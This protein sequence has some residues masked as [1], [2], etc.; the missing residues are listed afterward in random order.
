[1]NYLKIHISMIIPKNINRDLYNYKEEQL[2]KSYINPLIKLLMKS[3]LLYKLLN[4]YFHLKKNN[5]QLGE[6]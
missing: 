4:A 2:S 1:M 5:K 3:V 6:T